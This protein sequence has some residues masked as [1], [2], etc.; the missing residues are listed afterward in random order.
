MTIVDQLAPQVLLSIARKGKADLP[1]ARDR[2]MSAKFEEKVR[3]SA[4][5]TVALDNSD[6]AV[7]SA[8]P[9]LEKNSRLKFSF[10]YPG[11]M[12]GPIDMTNSGIPKGS[13]TLTIEARIRSRKRRTSS[14][15]KLSRSWE[16][17]AITEVVELVAA[18]MG[19]TGRNLDVDFDF[20]KHEHISQSNETNLELMHRLADMS[21][22]RFWIDEAGFQFKI[23]ATD[24]R[25]SALFQKV[26]GLIAPGMIVDYD[27]P[28]TL[29]R[30][31]KKVTLRGR[32]PFTRKTVSRTVSMDD[33]SMPV[34]SG[35]DIT[36]DDDTEF[37]TRAFSFTDAATANEAAGM[38]R[39]VKLSAV[40]MKLIVF[41]EPFVKPGF[42]VG[43]DRL[44]D[45]LDGTWYVW[46][47]AHDLGNGY[48]TE[49]MLG[50]EGYKR[51]SRK[52]EKT[53]VGAANDVGKKVST[54]AGTIFNAAGKVFREY[55]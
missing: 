8:T 23:P 35:N 5:L 7:W 43:V 4:K 40:K 49:L 31:P 28:K 47:T 42:T 25:P 39:E 46:D 9:L 27:L 54:V 30:V 20:E 24:V 32:N 17:V 6:G 38:M 14:D 33:R 16:N 34:L 53:L 26:P 29:K 12:R 18:E 50:R 3:G 37:V 41:G 2:I 48:F 36:A 55:K 10:G 13:H 15:G 19:Y 45:P 44:A 52:K 11:K 51:K 21:G 22:R 1:I